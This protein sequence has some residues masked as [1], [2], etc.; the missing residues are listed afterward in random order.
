MG[1]DEILESQH[2]LI[3]R[4]K[5]EVGLP[6]AK[7]EAYVDPVIR[8]YANYVHLLPASAT[9][10]HRGP[11][12]LFR[13]GLETAMWGTQAL[14]GR[15]IVM[16]RDLSPEQRYHEEPKWR[17][18]CLIACLC[19]D[20]GKIVTDM[21]V[22]TEDREMTWS[23]YKAPLAEWLKQSRVKRYWV[24]WEEDRHKVHEAVGVGFIERLV[25][26]SAY[27]WLHGEKGQFI[28]LLHRY[29]SGSEPRER[30]RNFYECIQWGDRTSV[31]RDLEGQMLVAGD[32]RQEVPVAQYVMDAMRRLLV[33]R[34]WTINEPGA[35]VWVGEGGEDEAYLLWP[36][37]IN[38]AVALLRQDEIPGI[39]GDPQV[40]AKLLWD[41]FALGDLGEEDEELQRGMEEEAPKKASIAPEILR[42]D[43]GELTWLSVVQLN[44]YAIGVPEDTPGVQLH[45]PAKPAASGTDDAEGGREGVPGDPGGLEQAMEQPM[46]RPAEPMEHGGVPSGDPGGGTAEK[47]EGNQSVPMEHPD[48]TEAGGVPVPG[49]V[50]HQADNSADAA[51]TA[52]DGTGGTPADGTPV[53]SGT[54]HG[55][56]DGTG[57]GI[58]PDLSDLDEVS[59]T[60]VETAAR[61]GWSAGR[62]EWA[63]PLE[64]LASEPDEKP[65]KIVQPYQALLEPDPERPMSVIRRDAESGKYVVLQ[66]RLGKRAEELA[67]ASVSGVPDGVSAREAGEST[68]ELGQHE[69]PASAADPELDP[70]AEAVSEVHETA[71]PMDAAEGPGPVEE[72]RGS[73]PDEG[74]GTEDLSSPGREV[75]RGD[76][77]EAAL[78]EELAEA[79]QQ[80]IEEQAFLDS[81]EKPSWVV[82]GAHAHWVDI[83]EAGVAFH[84]AEWEWVS[85]RIRSARKMILLLER[86]PVVEAPAA[87]PPE[88]KAKF[89]RRDRIRM[90]QRRH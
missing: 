18:A 59:R 62:R 2:R 77:E 71:A 35:R 52:G 46:E 50:E 27:D 15:L 67:A 80:W 54:P 8:T 79:F 28:A 37:A 76:S 41:R 90:V 83:N 78:I 1:V 21:R 29:L 43:D 55:T 11:G 58:A 34:R 6:P 82:P 47:A 65:L 56:A 14:Q 44:P 57:H 3:I 13:H 17:Y 89:S 25:P 32:E 33:D 30:D 31:K 16:G 7:G 5:E 88:V 74:R 45:H 85:K 87:I 68:E 81:D 61:T 12:G 63:V 51:S 20:I 60:L 48:G 73:G 10:H 53:G 86:A 36:E 72:G 75:A 24:N 49:R 9:H 38:E 39:P 84:K 4:V 19:H 26:E 64:A 70:S 23:P 40:V 42:R 22:V 66:R 69:A